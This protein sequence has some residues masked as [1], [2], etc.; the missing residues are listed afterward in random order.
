VASGVSIRKFTI[1]S[2]SAPALPKW[3]DASALSNASALLS[4]IPSTLI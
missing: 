3:S 2:W 4:L 1:N